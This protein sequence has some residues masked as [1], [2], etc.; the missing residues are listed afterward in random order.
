MDFFSDLVSQEIRKIVKEEMNS[1]FQEEE[2]KTNRRI[3]AALRI[4]ADMIESGSNDISSNPI[5]NDFKN[6]EEGEILESFVEPPDLAESSPLEKEEESVEP[7]ADERKAEDSPPEPLHG[8][9]RGFSENDEGI[10]D[11]EI[12]QGGE[13]S[14]SVISPDTSLAPKALEKPPEKDKDEKVSPEELMKSLVDEVLDAVKEVPEKKDVVLPDTYDL[15]QKIVFDKLVQGDVIYCGLPKEDSVLE[16]MDPSH[17]VRIY[18]VISKHY[19][20]L[21]CFYCSTKEKGD[22]SLRIP[23]YKGRCGTYH[24]GFMYLDK[25]QLVPA[26]DII[27]AV[28][29]LPRREMNEATKKINQAIANGKLPKN[30]PRFS[31]PEKG[32]TGNAPVLESTPQTVQN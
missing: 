18:V 17:R 32:G 21:L 1:R 19:D 27:E 11:I 8:S 25:T 12:E 31:L 10:A 30:T 16:K 5:L 6:F 2:E 3:A 15:K 23:M 28:G 26:K 29:R 9:F 14:P 13:E 22:P 24:D 20:K 4:A 7:R